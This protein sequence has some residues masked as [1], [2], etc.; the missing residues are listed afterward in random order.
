MDVLQ[1]Q[2]VAFFNKLRMQKTEESKILTEEMRQEEMRQH[3]S[4]RGFS[5]NPCQ[6]GEP[7][8]LSCSSTLSHSLSFPQWKQASLLHCLNLAHGGVSC[9]P[10]KIEVCGEG[11]SG[12][13]IPVWLTGTVQILLRVEEWMGGE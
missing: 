9:D 5:C 2:L 7:T 1:E 13:L 4:C 8:S 3:W 6:S 11:N 12:K 10:R